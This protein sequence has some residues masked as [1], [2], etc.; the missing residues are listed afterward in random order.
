MDGWLRARLSPRED[1]RVLFGLA[2]VA[3]LLMPLVFHLMLPKG[4]AG[5]HVSL[6][7]ETLIFAVFAT[8]FNLLYGYTGLLSFGHAMFVAVAGYAV[9]KVFTVVAPSLA[10]VGGVAPLVTWLVGVALGIVVAGVVGVF[11]GYLAVQLEEIYFALI[12]LSFSMAIYAAANQDVPGAIL[13]RFGIGDG[14]FTN[15]SDGLTFIPGEVDILGVEFLLV[16]LRDPAG[17]YVLTVFVFVA[18]TYAM[19]RIV[20]SPFGLT[21]RAIRENPQRAR[22]LGVDVTFHRW[23]TFIV[24]GLFSGLAGAMLVTLR[25]NV[26]PQDH[27]YWTASAEPVVMT[28]IGGPLSFVGPIVG[29]FTFEYLRWLISQNALLEQYRQFSFGVLLVVV[30]LFFENGVAGGMSWSAR[31]FRAWLEEARARYRADGIRGVAGLVVETV[32]GW[33]RAARAAVVAWVRTA[34]A[35]VVA[36]IRW[37]VGLVVGLT[38]W[39]V[40][41]FRGVRRRLPV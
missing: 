21:S 7:A 1:P 17:F 16:N 35:N 23:M 37:V 18:A 20:R 6:L 22:A 39:V 3:L 25:G 32:V 8:A 26:N 12:T 31:R 9:A 5:F 40:G 34:V 2:T 38:R 15:E 30:V 28:V 36:L 13:A 33:V 24:S 4:L 27:A 19:W 41:L 29:A 11:I 10:V 14:T